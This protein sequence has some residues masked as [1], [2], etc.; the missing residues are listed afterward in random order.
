MQLSPDTA[1]MH[2]INFILLADVEFHSATNLWILM[3][4]M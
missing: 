1:A 2:N 3:W 4:A